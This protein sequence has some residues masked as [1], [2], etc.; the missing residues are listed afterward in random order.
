M[1]TCSS[2]GGENGPL[3]SVFCEKC[4]KEREGWGAS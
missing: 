2:C 4:G 1:W 3:R